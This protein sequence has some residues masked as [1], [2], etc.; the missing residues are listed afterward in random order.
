MDGAQQST[1]KDAGH[2]HHVERIQCP[3]VEPLQEEQKAENCR[4]TEGGSEKPAALTQGIH[5]EHAH[6]HRD[7]PG[8]GDGVVGADPHQAGDLKLPQ[9]ETDQGERSVQRHEGPKTPQLAPAHKV[10]L[11]FWAPEQ[12]QAVTHCV[13]GG[14]D[15]SGDEVATFQVGAGNAVRVPGGDEGGAGQPTPQGQIGAGEEQ[16]T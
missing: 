10:A 15:G 5:Q 2:S 11:C 1:A 6:K 4:H 16:Q 3:V 14:A 7:R 9:H 12:Q 13:R 8:E